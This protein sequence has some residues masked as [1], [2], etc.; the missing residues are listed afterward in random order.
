MGQQCNSEWTYYTHL[1]A[2][3]TK[4]IYQKLS[5]INIL[6]NFNITINFGKSYL[7]CQIDEFPSTKGV[8]YNCCQSK[9][10]KF[11]SYTYSLSEKFDP[12]KDSPTLSIKLMIVN[13]NY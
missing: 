12:F 6:V 7:L 4:R 5:P 11:T 2:V 3:G 1:C 13:S 10:T 8:Y 9:F